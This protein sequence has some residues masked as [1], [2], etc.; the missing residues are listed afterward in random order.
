[1]KSIILGVLLGLLISYFKDIL[2]LI[3]KIIDNIFK[4]N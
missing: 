4:K 1:M 2:E 3:N